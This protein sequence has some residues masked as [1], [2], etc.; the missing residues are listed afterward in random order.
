MTTTLDARAA[1]AVRHAR[2]ARRR[3]AAANAAP[4]GRDDEPAIEVRDFSFWYGAHAGAARRVADGA[5]PRRHGAHRPVGMRQ[6]DLPA[7]DQPDER[8]DSRTPAPRANSW[9][10]ARRSTA[11]GSTWSRT[12]SGSAW[13]SSAPIRFPSR[14]STTWPTAR[15]STRWC[16]ERDLPDLVE[17]CLR[18]AALWDEVKDR[19]DAPATGLSGGQQQRLC[20]ARALGNQPDGAADGRALL[21]ARSDRHPEG[22]GADLSSSS[23]TTPS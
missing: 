11:P 13:C 10:R 19:L 14:S 9:S 15:R 2:T 7:L 3:R 17:R 6:V 16:R 5:A 4:T 22:R 18:Q 12:A 1:A 23:A 21:G 8:P 20:I